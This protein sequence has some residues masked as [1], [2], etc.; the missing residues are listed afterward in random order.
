[1]YMTRCPFSLSR[2]VKVSDTGQVIYQAEK[3][4]CRAF[5]D[6][7]GDDMQSGPKRNF[8]ILPPLDFLA[9]FTQHIPAKGSHLIRYYGWYS[10]KA[11]GMRKKAE[12]EASAEPP[13]EGAACAA[14]RSS[15]TWAML[16][17]R[18]YEVDPLSCPKCRGQMK[19]VSF[20]EPPQGEVIEKILQHCGLWQASVSPRAPPEVSGLVLELDATYSDSSIGSADQDQSQELTYVDIDTFLAGF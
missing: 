15:Q 2:L 4:A 8:Q 18:V 6:P 14:A 5:P 20:I 1:M 9:E 7:Q 17:K 10:N 16:I 12:A 11:R 19:V 13:S 3:Q